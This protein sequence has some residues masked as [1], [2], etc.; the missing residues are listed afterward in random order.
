VSLQDRKPLRACGKAF[1]STEDAERYRPV[2]EGRREVVTGCPC[3]KVHTQPVATGKPRT[4]LR[5]QGHD[6]GPTDAVRKL[7]LDRDGYCCVCCGKSI[8]GERYSLAHRVRAA[9]GGPATPENLVVLLGWGGEKCHGRVD[10]YKDRE[11][12]IGRK[13]YRLPSGADPAAEPVLIVTGEGDVFW[14]LLTPSGEY[15]P[16]QPPEQMDGAA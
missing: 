4:P 6:N 1:G 16:Q 13:G 7:V 14:A 2:I 5:P 12:G 9:Q 15:D 11:D 3:G 10:L 8:M